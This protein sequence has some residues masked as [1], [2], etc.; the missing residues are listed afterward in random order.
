MNINDTEYSKAKSF[1]GYMQVPVTVFDQITPFLM[2]DQEKM[3]VLLRDMPTSM[4]KPVWLPDDGVETI[5]WSGYLI[6]EE[7]VSET[8]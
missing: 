4:V 8:V 1:R 2:R 6:I 7:P 5:E 3:H